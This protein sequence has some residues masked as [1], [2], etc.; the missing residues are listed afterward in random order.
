MIDKGATAAPPAASPAKEVRQRAAAQQ[1]Q[2]SADNE[3]AG[4]RQEQHGRGG[5]AQAGAGSRGNQH[6]A[7]AERSRVLFLRHMM[8]AGGQASKGQR[9]MERQRR[10][11]QRRERAA[12]GQKEVAGSHGVGRHVEGQG[13]SSLAGMGS[14]GLQVVAPACWVLLLHHVVDAEG[15]GGAGSGQDSKKYRTRQVQGP[16][17]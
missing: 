4:G 16:Q 1:P 14:T 9:R 6:R 12:G 10:V 2:C 17:R 3:D 7:G 11:G 13:R 5:G 8:G 15:Q